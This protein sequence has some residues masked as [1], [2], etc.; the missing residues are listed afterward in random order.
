MFVVLCFGI[1]AYA[2]HN[3][4]MILDWD[5]E[6]FDTYQEALGAKTFI[7]SA[8]L[9]TLIHS[10]N[11]DVASIFMSKVT[12]RLLLHLALQYRMFTLKSRSTIHKIYP[13]L[14]L[15]EVIKLKKNINNF[16]QFRTIPEG[17]QGRY[18]YAL[19]LSFFSELSLK[20]FSIFSINDGFVLLIPKKHIV[21]LIQKISS[22][23]NELTD[24]QENE[25]ALFEKM[26]GFKISN[27][28]ITDAQTV[29]LK[30]INVKSWIH[31][32]NNAIGKLFTLY[33]AY[34]KERQFAKLGNLVEF[35]S[36][37]IL[38]NGHGGKDTIAGFTQAEFA[39]FLDFLKFNVPMKS[40][41]YS[42]CYI[43][44][45]KLYVPFEYTSIFQQEIKVGK[46][47]P[48]LII[49]SAYEQVRV[50]RFSFVE[51]DIYHPSKRIEDFFVELRAW[52]DTAS[53]IKGKLFEI[54]SLL[55]IKFNFPFNIPA[56]RYPN[57]QWFTI[58]DVNDK[59]FR[60]SVVRMFAA[61]KDNKPIIIKNKELCVI[62]P[63]LYVGMREVSKSKEGITISV[64]VIFDQHNNAPYIIM[65]VPGKAGITFARIGAQDIGFQDLLS[66]LCA[67]AGQP[68]ERIIRINNLVCSSKNSDKIVVT[69]K[70]QRKMR[71]VQ[72]MP[73]ENKAIEIDDIVIHMNDN[74]GIHSI[75][76]SFDKKRYQAVWDAR[77]KDTNK[78]LIEGKQIP[79]FIRV[80]S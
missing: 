58:M 37:C 14:G 60:L 50:E 8:M 57:T 25:I 35:P 3:L 40:L 67:S 28:Q 24:L 56:V 9:N 11:Q 80:N 6:T 48:F 44:G 63:D 18:F 61:I 38:L 1:H 49:A 19:L 74:D 45:T 5:E 53:T 71:S 17:Y 39:K 16:N 51:K 31:S 52:L 78:K 65:M 59:V 10:L 64:D 34:Q 32:L 12:L 79:R 7:N 70:I 55:P 73:L 75:E 23:K 66:K 13:K 68:A 36:W 27:F 69:E 46:A 41:F 29:L 30:D 33:T 43:G 26:S 4:V 62:E 42:T 15:D 47:Y 20:K 76:F 54:C 72:I 2:Q 77:D 21:S 22:H